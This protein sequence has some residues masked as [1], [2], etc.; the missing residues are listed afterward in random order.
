MTFFLLREMNLLPKPTYRNLMEV[1]SQRVADVVADQ[2]PR[3]AGPNSGRYLFGM[4]SPAE[5][6][7]SC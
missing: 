2:T 4:D 1:V 6:R 3:A 7:G 5:Q